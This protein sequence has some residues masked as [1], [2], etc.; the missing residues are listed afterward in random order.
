MPSTTLK[1]DDGAVQFRQR[2]VVA[3]FSNRPILIRNIHADNLQAPGL[4][5]EEASFLRLIDKLTNGTAIE[6]NATGTQ[7]RLKPGILVGG[8]V[9]HDCPETRNVGWFLEGI[10]PLAPF[11]K[12]PLELTL[13]GVTQGFTNRDP[14]CDYIKASILPIMEKFGI[15][16]EDTASPPLLKVITKSTTSSGCVEFSCPQVKQLLPIDVAEEGK[17]KRIRGLAVSTRLP[18][19]ATA[20]VAHASKGV[21]HRLLPDVWIHTDATSVSKAKHTN[22]NTTGPSLSMLLTAESTTGV[23]LST[24]CAWNPTNQQQRGKELPEDLGVKGATML[25]QEVQCGG[26]VD[27]GCQSLVLLFMCLGPEDVAR[28]RMG[29]LSQYTIASLRLFQQ[30]FGVEFKVK[31]DH[32]SKTVLLSCLGTGYRNMARA[33]T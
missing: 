2:L 22:K 6:I 9:E 23:V 11:S 15:A 19:T 10:L 31:A 30:A 16:D 21:L 4:Q 24:E 3:L 25:L 13:H 29:T 28:I 14:S 12:V 7:L 8:Q 32:E 1:F 26:C 5:P 18:P 17:I 33:S 20:R 27:S